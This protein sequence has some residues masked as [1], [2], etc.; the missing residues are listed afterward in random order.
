[1]GSIMPRYFFNTRIGD[2]L[3]ADLNQVMPYDWA[4][5]IHQRVD[6]VNPR[7]DLAGIEQGGYRLVYKDKPSASE[8]TMAAAGG[9]R[10]GGINAWYSIGLRVGADGTI[11]DVRWNGPADKANIG[12]G[13]KIL[14]VNGKIFSAD[15]L[16]EAIRDAKGAKEQR[17]ERLQGG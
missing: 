2:E 5:F 3:I 13:A 4:G 9:R 8:R 17:R 7:A 10:G 6:L 11:S 14:A 1:M 16:K 12:P 15:A